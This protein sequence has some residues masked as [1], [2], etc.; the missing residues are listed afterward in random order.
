V[1]LTPESPA[2]RPPSAKRPV[3]AWQLPEEEPEGLANKETTP[4]PARRTSTEER[5][6]RL[7]AYT[8]N[9]A[10]RFG[11]RQQ[12]GLSSTPTTPVLLGTVA[13]S[14]IKYR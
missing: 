7:D 4:S 8:L 12:P 3:T 13:V 11:T 5:L 10:A 1:I 9:M 6:A 14:N 2:N